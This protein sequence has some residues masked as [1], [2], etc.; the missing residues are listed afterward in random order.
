MEGHRSPGC[1]ACEFQGFIRQ[2]VDYKGWPERESYTKATD[3]PSSKLA[4]RN[5]YQEML[6]GNSASPQM[7][8]QKTR[9]QRNG[10]AHLQFIPYPTA[11]GSWAWHL[12]DKVLAGH[13]RLLIAFSLRDLQAALC[14]R[15]PC[16]TDS[17]EE[18]AL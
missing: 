6:T 17:V 4:T 1:L 9:P 14:S 3:S 5:E 18:P 2:P 15:W 16:R 10:L 7:L 11:G 12:P 13:F 8:T